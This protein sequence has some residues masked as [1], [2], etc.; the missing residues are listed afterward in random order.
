MGID[1]WVRQLIVGLQNRTVLK[2]ICT[3][4][5]SSPSFKLCI[6][7]DFWKR[8]CSVD[9]SEP[10]CREHFLVS[11]VGN[12]KIMSARSPFFFSPISPP[13]SFLSQCRSGE[14][15]QIFRSHLFKNPGRYIYTK[16]LRSRVQLQDSVVGL[17]SAQRFDDH[18]LH[19]EH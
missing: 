12:I 6:D 7:L 14:S 10:V 5:P 15:G 18:G 2:T 1:W 16:M 17:I 4:D 3:Q 19:Q 8:Y 13:F 11:K 9:V